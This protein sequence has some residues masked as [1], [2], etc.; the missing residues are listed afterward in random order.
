M[1]DHKLPNNE[2]EFLAALMDFGRDL[3]RYSNTL[4]EQVGTPR[5]VSLMLYQ[6]LWSNFRAFDALWSA[7][8]M[9]EAQ[10]IIR[11]A[12]EAAICL[13]ANEKLQGDFYAMLLGDLAATL[14][15]MVKL[16]RSIDAPDLV[17]KYEARLRSLPAGTPDQPSA[18]IWE[19][20]AKATGNQLLYDRHRFLSA[21]SAHVTGISLMRGVTAGE[22]AEKLQIEFQEIDKQS[23]PLFMGC[24]FMF[25]ARVH[26]HVVAAGAL[27]GT[28][29]ALNGRLRELIET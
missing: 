9:L 6:R 4:A 20:L 23:A 25:G 21:T 17:S 1:Q 28:A 18:F 7:G 29:D 13:A 14:K 10:I 3:S 12:I 8:C 5:A 19:A 26:A 2:N 27:A 11:T 22:E 24:V 15:K 16:W